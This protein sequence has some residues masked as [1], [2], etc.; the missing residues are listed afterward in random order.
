MLFA[1][2]SCLRGIIN[3]AVLMV[4][5]GLRVSGS[6]GLYM[7]S[8]SSGHNYSTSSQGPSH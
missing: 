1:L 4:R 3:K 5:T 8:S 7:A 2:G 6:E